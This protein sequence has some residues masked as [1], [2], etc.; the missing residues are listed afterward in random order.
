MGSN[1]R[2]NPG[3]LPSMLRSWFEKKLKLPTPIPESISTWEV[4]QYVQR[5]TLG[6]YL[7]GLYVRTKFKSCGKR[8]FAG[9][10]GKF[11]FPGYI[12]LGNDV[13]I[14]SHCYINGLSQ[15]GFQI[16]HRVHIREYGWIQATSQLHD[17]GVGITIGDDTYIGPYCYLGAG[18]GIQMGRQVT[19]GAHVHILAENHA[20]QDASKPIQEQGVT[21]KGVIIED[22]V[23]I[24]NQVIILDGVRVGRGS[25]IGAGSVVTHDVLP[26][27]V[28]AGNPS[29]VLRTR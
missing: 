11:F 28:V 23:W 5:K 13:F 18:G 4:F 17:P 6:P 16:G 10:N 12:S 29:R 19:L 1:R 26:H 27:N 25:V 7:R 14:G 15:K 8:L 21:R 20:F 24:G 3:D 9:S 2:K 22:D